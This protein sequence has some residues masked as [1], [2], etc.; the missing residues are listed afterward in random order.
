MSGPWEKYGGGQADGPWAK[1][2]KPPEQSALGY[3][4][5]QARTSIP[6]QVGIGLARGVKDVIDTGA[7]ALASG[8]DRI[9]GTREGERVA[10]MNQAGKEQ[11]ARDNPTI[12]ASLGRVGGNVAATLPV[13][14][15]LGGAAQAARAPAAL[16][17]SL[18]T[19][20]M[21]AGNLPGAAGLATRMAGGAAT[22]G[23]SAALIDPEQA[24][25]G[26]IVGAALPAAMQVGG[27]IGRAIGWTGGAAALPAANQ[28]VRDVAQRGM[29]EG[30]V[31]P[32]SQ[33]NP[34]MKNRFLESAGGKISTAQVAS[35]K[36]QEVTQRLVRRTLGMADDAPLTQEA[37]ATY[38]R[39]QSQAGYE[40]LRQVGVIPAGKPFE[41]AL[42]D[43]LRSTTGKGTIPAVQ[44]QD[45]ADLIASH[46]S[47][48][49]DA[50]DAVDAIR[51]LRESADDAFR[52]GD[53]ALARAQ[54]GIAQAYEQAI[55]DGLR[56][57]GQP[58]LLANYRIARKNIAQS[59]NIEPAIREG[60]GGVDARVLA[61]QL[62]KGEPLTGNLRTIAEFANTFDKASQ[63]PWLIGSPDVNNLRP[64]ASLL[65]GSSL[66]A[67]GGALVG[68]P[69]G[70]A[71]GAAIPMIAPRAA[72]SVMFRPGF[73][74]GLLAAG[75]GGGVPL[76][77]LLPLTYR[78]APA[79]AAGSQ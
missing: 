29:A 36:N 13:G 19:F 28:Q 64:L 1:Y 54:R 24:A 16:V 2:A 75:Q 39:A 8:F 5:E 9:A 48:G 27:A 31:V 30:Y 63:P 69:V 38:R 60:G 71:V 42:D 41:Q 70:A 74:Q 20:G 18:R 25:T 45:I 33:L 17:E 26:A 53:S 34:S 7:Q 52:R 56:A 40:P 76:S 68:G 21:S 72:Q 51:V 11:F 35:T 67:G 43:V 73:Q 79:V 57:V 59:F 3:L 44:R 4:A 37:L 22:G 77:A 15:V 32:P 10:A 66:G 58:D 6:G 47:Q 46:R 14:Q 62:Q 78:A 12:S 65:T 50:G 49:F 61:R 55:D 23:V